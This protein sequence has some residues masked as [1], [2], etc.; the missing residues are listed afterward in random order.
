M[1][2]AYYVEGIRFALGA[3]MALTRPALQSI[4]GLAALADFL[5][6]DYQLGWRVAQTG[7]KVKLLP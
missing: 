2:T 1:A 6:D 4:G 5:A 3:T 7:F